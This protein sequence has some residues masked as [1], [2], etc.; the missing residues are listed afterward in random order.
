MLSW[1]IISNK[2]HFVFVNAQVGE[3]VLMRAAYSFVG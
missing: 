1:L 3:A 2:P